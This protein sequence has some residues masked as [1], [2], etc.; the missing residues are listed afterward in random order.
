MKTLNNI[1][2]YLDGNLS[3]EALLDFEKQ[4]K[5]DLSFKKEVLLNAEINESIKD[6][7]VVEFRQL[8]GN[9]ISKSK[10]KQQT[11]R[12]F[13]YAAASIIVILS[14]LKI[15]YP[16][17][18]DKIYTAFY[19]PYA[20]NMNVRSDNNNMGNLEFA[21]QLY[22]EGKYQLS[23]D[24]LSKYNKTGNTSEKAIFYEALCALELQK[25]DMAENLFHSVVQTENPAL[26]LHVNWYLGLTYLKNNKN[27]KAIALLDKLANEKNF[28][29][30]KAKRILKKVK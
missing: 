1:E 11:I 12:L 27:D 15:T 8:V 23:F 19:A 6:T 20:T 2:N 26:R 13:F 16:T 4:F 22:G 3:G 10:N 24:L 21:Y 28:Y 7:D 17:S 9:L 29:T 14:V 30:D 5:E 18:P 25:Y